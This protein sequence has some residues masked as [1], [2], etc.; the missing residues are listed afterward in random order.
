[1]ESWRRRRV[2]IKTMTVPNRHLDLINGHLI[3]VITSD[4]RRLAAGSVEILDPGARSGTMD[5]WTTLGPP[6]SLAPPATLLTPAVK[7]LWEHR[8]C[9]GVRKQQV[10]SCMVN[11][12]D[13]DDEGGLYCCSNLWIN[14]I[15]TIYLLMIDWWCIALSGI[16]VSHSLLTKCWTLELCKYT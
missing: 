6:I 16:F 5:H 3:I 9:E 8:N 11:K 14:G 1:M 2:E 10:I 13:D 7:V 15:S 4:T 12:C